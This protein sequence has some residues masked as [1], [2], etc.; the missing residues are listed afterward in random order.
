M[1]LGKLEVIACRC[2][3]F[4]QHRISLKGG[5]FEACQTKQSRCAS[6]NWGPLPT[7]RHT[8]S[9]SRVLLDSLLGVLDRVEEA[10]VGPWRVPAKIG[11]LLLGFDSVFN[12]LTLRTRSTT[13]HHEV[14]GSTKKVPVA[15]M[16]T[17]AGVESEIKSTPPPP[18][19]PQ[20]QFLRGLPC[21]ETPQ[22]HCPTQLRR[23]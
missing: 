6:Q 11:N 22:A 4:K 21:W 15:E 2:Q 8:P 5:S 12:T 18:P 3:P 23:V 16:E 17:S 14:Q 7:H 19:P 20:P 10:A 9:P 1:Q 13:I